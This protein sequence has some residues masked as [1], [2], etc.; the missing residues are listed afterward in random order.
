MIGMWDDCNSLLREREECGMILQRNEGMDMGLSQEGLKLIACICMLIDHIGALFYPGVDSLR[1]VGRIAFPIFCFLLV[2]GAHYTRN[3]AK[4]AGR[5]M[6]GAVI[7][8]IPFDLAFSGRIDPGSCSVMVTLLLGYGAILAV[9]H[10]T[11]FRKG[12][13]ILLCFFMAELL[14]T[15][16]A[17]NGIA[18]IV[19]L[20]VAREMGKGELWRF[21]GLAVLLWFGYEVSLG[22]VRVP[23]ELFG[24]LSLVPIHFYR[25]EKRTSGRLVQ[26]GF[27]LFYPVHLLILWGIRGF[28]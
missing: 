28:A 11:G 16:Y 27:Y 19:W 20:A 6:I 14:R 17:G 22:P 4:Y 23:L 15:D 5:L 7:S 25:G 9:K 8:E 24:L 3:P 13:V 1:I 12:I 2:E 10:M 26:W 18:I 21:A